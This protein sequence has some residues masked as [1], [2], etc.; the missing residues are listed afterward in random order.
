LPVVLCGYEVSQVKGNGY[1]VLVWKEGEHLHDP[2]VDGREV[3]KWMFKK[4]DGRVW[5]KYIWFHM[6]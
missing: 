5:T 6:G 4:E 2:G 1:W 3:L